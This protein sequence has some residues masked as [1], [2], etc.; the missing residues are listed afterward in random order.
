METGDRIGKFEVL[1][2]LR[3]GGMGEV[4]LAED[5]RTCEKVALKILPRCHR[6]NPL[7]IERFQAEAEMYR[8]L[9]HPNVVR[10]IDADTSTGNPFVALEYINGQ[11]LSQVLKDLGRIPV[12]MAVSIMLD[13][14]YALGFAHSRGIIHRDIKPQN[15][16]LD[17]H[18]VI[19]LIDF[20]VARS[21]ASMVQTSAGTVL[22][23]LC[24]NSPEQNQ[25]RQVDERSDVYSL[26]LLFYELLTGE[27]AITARSLTQILL[28]Q[29]ELE[30]TLPSPQQRGVDVPEALDRLIMEMLSYD[31][32]D[33]PR[34]MGDVLVVLQDLVEGNLREL[35]G[36]ARATK[37][38]A[39][40]D[41]AD[42]HYWKA[43]NALAEQ[44]WHAALD[45]FE[46]LLNL[47]LFDHTEYRRQVEEQLHFMAWKLDA[48]QEDPDST[49]EA[50]Q[51]MVGGEPD[52]SG[53]QMDVLQKLHQ[54]YRVNPHDG[55][56]E[57]MSNL[58]SF[59]RDRMRDEKAR[60]PRDRD[61]SKLDPKAY[62]MAMLKV[63]RLYAKLGNQEQQKLIER[64]LVGSLRRLR[65]PALAAGLWREVR[66][67]GSASVVLLKGHADHLALQGRA[68]D[69]RAARLRA[70][71][72]HQRRDEDAAAVRLLGE[73][74]EREPDDARLKD[75]LARARRRLEAAA[76]RSQALLELLA[77]LEEAHDRATAVNHCIAFLGEHPDDLRVLEKLYMLQIGD[78]SPASSADTLVRWGVAL[79][80]RGE[81]AAARD[82]FVEALHLQADHPDAVGHLVDLLREEDP[83]L[84]DRASGKEIRRELYVRLGMAEQAA[85]DLEKRLESRTGDPI[86]LERLEEI[87]RRCRRT[88]RAAELARDQVR[89]ALD[90]H[91][92]GEAR[93]L[94]DRFLARYVDR[95]ELLRPLASHPCMLRDPDLIAEIVH[96]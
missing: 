88:E 49:P 9:L 29:A 23:S 2:P 37:H 76:K 12:D 30:R 95:R 66:A 91:D 39:E 33:R 52:L 27:R 79:R 46:H 28:A 53:L 50:I 42:T 89:L 73:M 72:L 81:D 18:N 78:S 24:Y 25:G 35:G 93:A 44:D 26:G 47:S 65:D 85:A 20:G 4:Y 64:K 55:I 41:R 57:A 34:G 96:R 31:R 61:G 7:L 13:I 83:S 74:C 63:A 10:F 58:L 11:D 77:M 86:L 84:C 71:R 6:Q 43:M 45:E 22:G 54:I 19:K 1:V 80:E 36:E 75:R 69:A 68:R 90:G 16:M 94:V 15:V 70:V 8:H 56:R 87:Y 60:P 40:R 17:R 62:T 14:A 92:I 51:A 32:E 3:A 21:E 38:A 67:K 5:M 82:R 48:F 59:Y